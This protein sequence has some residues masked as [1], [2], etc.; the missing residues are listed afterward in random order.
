MVIR[1]RILALTLAL[2]LVLSA[3]AG[4]MPP[5]A[6]PETSADTPLASQPPELPRGKRRANACISE[7]IGI[8]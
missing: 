3:C 4:R 2:C 7:N 5:P 8:R 1:G 6:P